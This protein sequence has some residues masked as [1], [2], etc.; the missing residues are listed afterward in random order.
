MHQKTIA[1]R[2]F[3]SQA[4]ITNVRNDSYWPQNPVASIRIPKPKNFLRYRCCLTVV[5]PQSIRL[6]LAGIMMN[7]L[8][9]Y[10]ASMSLA[11]E[12][13]HIM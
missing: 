12:R 5:L 10:R 4:Y 7:S 3:F 9:L 1:L 13:L 8:Y 11:A 6:N 2:G